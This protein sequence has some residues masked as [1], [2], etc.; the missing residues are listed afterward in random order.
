MPL[1]AEL[2]SLY[3]D[4]CYKD[5]APTELFFDLAATRPSRVLE[6]R[7]AEKKSCSDHS[8]VVYLVGHES[9]TSVL[10]ACSLSGDASF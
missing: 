4:R 7:T 9:Q 3:D 1:L 6:S 8:A 10:A 2:V 5:F